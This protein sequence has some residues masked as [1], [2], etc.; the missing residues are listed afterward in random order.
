MNR[1]NR[2][3]ACA[4]APGGNETF[5]PKER[6]CWHLRR[7]S[8][9]VNA[10]QQRIREVNQYDQRLKEAERTIANQRR[11]LHQMN[12][13]ATARNQ[14]IA[15]LEGDKSSFANVR[16][17]DVAGRGPDPANMRAAGSIAAAFEETDGEGNL[18]PTTE[19]PGNCVC[20]DGCDCE[21]RE[22]CPCTDTTAVPEFSPEHHHAGD[23]DG[24]Q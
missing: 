18:I 9:L 19:N 1:K 21:G 7:I 23:D 6:E 12:L 2:R 14:R 4:A 16:S 10:V 22:N 20:S 17:T 15:T 5:T 8:Q 24:G 11:T 3:Q 13:K